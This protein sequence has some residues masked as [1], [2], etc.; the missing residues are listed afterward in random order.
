MTIAARSHRE[1]L[2]TRCEHSGPVRVRRGW[3]SRHYLFSVYKIVYAKAHGRQNAAT[4]HLHILIVADC[5]GMNT[6]KDGEM[7]TVAGGIPS[8]S[9][10][11]PSLTFSRV[12]PSRTSTD[13][14][15]CLES[16]ET[17]SSTFQRAVR[18]S[19]K[20][21]KGFSTSAV[22]AGAT[23]ITTAAIIETVTTT[24]TAPAAMTTAA[25]T[26]VETV[27]TGTR[28]R[29]KRRTAAAKWGMVVTGHVPVT[30]VC[31]SLTCW[32]NPC[33]SQKTRTQNFP[34]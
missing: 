14:Q 2:S 4:L 27:A 20:P 1:A 34:S 31:V 32:P 10:K 5:S 3:W 18:I 30:T 6:G 17:S 7:E 24:E 25:I 11:A 29:T 26:T 12:S 22:T 21:Y 19:P 16:G 33:L 9:P 8:P 15:A 13:P 28:T 23:T